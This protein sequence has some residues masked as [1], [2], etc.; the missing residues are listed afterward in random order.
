MTAI[1]MR[2]IISAALAAAPLCASSVTITA[3]DY[4]LPNVSADSSYTAATNN[5]G[6]LNEGH[7]HGVFIPAAS[8]LVTIGGLQYANY[9]SGLPGGY[10]LT[11]ASLDFSGLFSLASTTVS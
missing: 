11:G 5:G 10:V 2:V 9:L 4:T 1:S 6:N 7:D 8:P 3:P